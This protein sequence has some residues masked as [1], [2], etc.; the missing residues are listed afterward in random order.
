M[1]TTQLEV[2]ECT[3]EVAARRHAQIARTASGL[4]VRWNDHGHAESQEFPFPS[5]YA[6]QEAAF[7]RAC[8][9]A[10]AWMCGNL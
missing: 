4:V 6:S 10:H 2:P 5:N 3:K 1:K 9:D 7:F 8:S